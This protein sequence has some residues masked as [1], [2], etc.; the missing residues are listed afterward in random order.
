MFVILSRF[1]SYKDWFQ[2][3]GL[4]IFAGL[5]RLRS[6]D[7][8]SYTLAAIWKIHRSI[9][10]D[11]LRA[12]LRQVSS[13]SIH[14]S[15][16]TITQPS[17]LLLKKNA[18]FEWREEHR[19]AFEDK[20]T[21]LTFPFPLTPSQQGKPLLYITS[22]QRPIGDLLDLEVDEIE[23]LIQYIQLA[24]ARY[25]LHFKAIVWLS[26]CYEE[27]P[28]LTPALP[29]PPYYRV[30]FYSLHLHL[31]HKLPNNTASSLP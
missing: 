14:P 10:Q 6:I 20:K 29:S 16:A 7:P 18:K 3:T 17:S 13:L 4:R 15:H 27:A 9:N 2:F 24:E 8:D 22:N 26:F 23:Q 25:F 11:K 5:A 30:W 31:R 19:K 21:A 1:T 28:S 12:F